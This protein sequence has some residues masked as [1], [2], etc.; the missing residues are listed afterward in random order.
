[1]GITVKWQ[2]EDKKTLL[3]NYDPTWTWEDFAAS[4]VQIDTMLHS[5]SHKVSIISDSR[6]SNGLPRGNALAVLSRS[7]QSAPDNIG[8]VAVLG[9]NPF[10]K[11]LLQILQTVSLNRAA[12]NIRFVKNEEA[13]K[14]VVSA[15]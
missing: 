2:A 10:F 4:K 15:A 5:V 8:T 9:A 7:F 13:A 11:S 6:Q 3:V 1:M 12:K 14:S